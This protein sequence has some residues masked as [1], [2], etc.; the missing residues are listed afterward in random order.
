[1]AGRTALPCSRI[2][3]TI[4]SPSS[5]LAKS[6]DSA[7]LPGFPGDLDPGTGEV[8][9]RWFIAVDNC[10]VLGLQGTIRRAGHR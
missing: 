5:E 1:M 3:S 6:S 9:V 7:A 8:K 2:V 4:A 10:G